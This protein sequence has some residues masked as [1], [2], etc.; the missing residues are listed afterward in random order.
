[1]PMRNLFVR[2]LNRKA[3][4]FARLVNTCRENIR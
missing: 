1:M 4:T 2:E 3:G